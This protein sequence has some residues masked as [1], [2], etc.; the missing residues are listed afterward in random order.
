MRKM[1]KKQTRN[2]TGRQMQ[3]LFGGEAY[4]TASPSQ[5]ETSYIDCIDNPLERLLKRLQKDFFSFS[6]AQ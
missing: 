6:Q 4:T 2:L 5:S 1:N 3:D